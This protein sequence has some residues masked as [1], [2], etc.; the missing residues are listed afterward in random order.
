MWVRYVGLGGTTDPVGVAAYLHGHVILDTMQRDLV[1]HAINELLEELSGKQSPRTGPRDA[2]KPIEADDKRARLI[3]GQDALVGRS[4]SLHPPALRAPYNHEPAGHHVQD[5][6]KPAQTLL[7]TGLS[8]PG[9][10]WPALQTRLVSM[11]DPAEAENRR[12]ASLRSTG[13]FDSGPEERFDRITRQAQQKFEVNSSTISF[14][15]RDRQVLKSSVGPLG[16]DMPRHTS[17]CFHTIAEDKILVIPDTIEDSLFADNDLV[18]GSAPIRFYAGH[19]LTGPGG[20]RIGALCILDTEPRD[21]TEQDQRD[22]RTLANL[23]Q[24]QI[25][26]P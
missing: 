8:H 22:F 10:S 11:F 26:R 14:I 6:A 1:T 23:T 21:F 15:G 17:F 12:L 25:Y 3:F 19:P 16:G 7:G 2:I 4:T 24:L 5:T 9:S 20:W 18:R 13:L